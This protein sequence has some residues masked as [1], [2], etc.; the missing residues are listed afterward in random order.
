MRIQVR[1]M[2]FIPM[3]NELKIKIRWGYWGLRSMFNRIDIKNYI[4][5]SY[6]VILSRDI[7]YVQ[8]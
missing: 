5:T 7:L 1:L 6:L 4:S 2:T 8:N 3:I